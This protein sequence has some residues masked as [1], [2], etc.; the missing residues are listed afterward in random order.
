MVSDKCFLLSDL[1]DAAYAALVDHGSRNPGFD[2]PPFFYTG[3]P[4]GEAILKMGCPEVD[5]PRAWRAEYVPQDGVEPW[6]N[7][8][9]IWPEVFGIEQKKDP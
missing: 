8:K 3:S 2:M 9:P 7:R 1:A 4:Y 5:P 6:A